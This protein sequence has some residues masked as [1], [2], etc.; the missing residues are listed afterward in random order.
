MANGPFHY[1]T[2]HEAMSLLG[3]SRATIDRWRKDKQ[4]PSIK[5]GKEVFFDEEQIKHWMLN[6]KQEQQ[7]L[8]AQTNQRM[9]ASPSFQQPIQISIGFQTGA[10]QLWSPIIMKELALFEEELT[11][12]FPRHSFNISWVNAPNGMELVERLIAGNVHI[13]S[14]GDYPISASWCLNQLLPSFKPVFLAFDGKTAGNSGISLV[15]PKG[16]NIHYPDQ[17]IHETLSAVSGSSSAYRLDRWMQQH[18]LQSDAIVHR[19]MGLCLQDIMAGSISASM[20]WEPYLSWMQQLNAGR[21]IEDDGY[22]SDYLAGVITNQHWVEQ[23]EGIVICYLKA[24][25]KAHQYIR[26]NT[27]QAAFI[28]HRNSGYPVEVVHQ[29]LSRILWDASIYQRDVEALI[30]LKQSI[31]APTQS[32]LQPKS[33]TMDIQPYYLQRAVEQL[34]L[35]LLPDVPRYGDW[36][37]EM[38]Y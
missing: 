19:T 31:S 36:S 13:A 10:A 2:I 7:P 38:L 15:V 30:R 28:I 1:L 18:R 11:N 24:H 37:M 22:S 16:S 9:Q 6:Y 27:E 12:E 32:L 17:L 29:S 4:L 20:L 5:I 35:P 25:L 14:V 23:H 33:S 8:Q 26:D 21:L 3:V 34:K